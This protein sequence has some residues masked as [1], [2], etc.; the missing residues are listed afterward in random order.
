MSSNRPCCLGRP[1]LASL[2]CSSW[3]LQQPGAPSPGATKLLSEAL[4]NPNPN[5]PSAELLWSKQDTKAKP[6]P[7]PCQSQP[8]KLLPALTGP[9]SICRAGLWSSSLGVRL[10]T[11][12]EQQ[13]Q[14]VL[15]L[16]HRSAVAACSCSRTRCL[17]ACLSVYLFIRRPG[18]LPFL[19]CRKTPPGS[20]PSLHKAWSREKRADRSWAPGIWRC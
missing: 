14:A 6:Q 16:Q 4:W 12:L 5:L 15:R 9:A 13:A 7:Q 11:A 20:F 1:G 10:G 18:G 3:S 2:C 17:S 8:G 19:R